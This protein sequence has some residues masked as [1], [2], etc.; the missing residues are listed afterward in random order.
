MSLCAACGAELVNGGY[1]CPYHHVST[2]DDWAEGNRVFCDLFHRGKEPA[3]SAEAP[4]HD[5]P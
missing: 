4:D 1:L 5:A 2:E 3:R